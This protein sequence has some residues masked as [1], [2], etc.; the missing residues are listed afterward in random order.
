[1]KTNILYLS[2]VC[3]AVNVQY[4]LKSISW[5]LSEKKTLNARLNYYFLQ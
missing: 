4:I 1:M 5:I 2:V 3:N